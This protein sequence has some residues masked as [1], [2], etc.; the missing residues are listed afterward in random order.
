MSLNASTCS[1]S[2]SISAGFS[3]ATTRQK[4]HSVTGPP[5]VVAIIRRSPNRFDEK[6]SGHGYVSEVQAAHPQERQPHQ[7]RCHLVSQDLSRASSEEILSDARRDRAAQAPCFG[8]RH[9][10]G[11]SGR[12]RRVSSPS[13]TSDSS[14]QSGSGVSGLGSTAMMSA[15]TH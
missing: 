9:W 6:E 4:T 5:D 11:A 3:R 7:A 1:S 14:I 15:P 10:H 13:V 12:M 8:R 2:Y